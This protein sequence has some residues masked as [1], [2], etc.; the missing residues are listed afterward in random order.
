MLNYII[1]G[2]GLSG[3]CVAEELLSRGKKILVFDDASQNSSTV[4][5][6]LYNPVI[7]K[8][9]TLA[10]N[11]GKQ[12]EIAIPFYRELEKKLGVPLLEEL[13]VYRKFSS[14][15]E[16]NNWFAAMDK[17]QVEP[18]LDTKLT[19]TVN[20]NV[21]SNYSFG[22]VKGTGRINTALLIKKYRKYLKD[23]MYLWMK[24]KLYRSKHKHRERI[25]LQNNKR[26]E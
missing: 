24:H 8:R 5:G 21:P 2:A 4:A 1:V 7:L 26:F 14:V 19:P 15:E 6:G 20:M 16:Q 9:F 22:R 18:F 12:L 10:W 3:I 25:H 23:R 13:P 17:P 11:A